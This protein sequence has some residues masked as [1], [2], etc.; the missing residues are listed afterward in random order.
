MKVAVISPIWSTDLYTV[1]ILLARP[2]LHLWIRGLSA[3]HV[4]PL[5]HHRSGARPW[6]HVHGWPLPLGHPWILVIVRRLIR[7]L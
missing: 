7:H 3:W 6:S 4:H 1:W 2:D 5:V